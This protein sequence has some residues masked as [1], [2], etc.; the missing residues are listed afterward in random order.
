MMDEGI[1]F[2]VGIPI[3]VRRGRDLLCSACRADNW[4]G[5]DYGGIR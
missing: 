3:G 5:L 4:L 2:P 1:R